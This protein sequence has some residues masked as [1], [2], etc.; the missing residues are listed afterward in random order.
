MRQTRSVN[1]APARLP[2]VRCRRHEESDVK[3]KFDTG[4]T[5]GMHGCGEAT[6]RISLVF[7][8]AQHEPVG[9]AKYLPFPVNGKTAASIKPHIVGFIGF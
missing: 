9:Y 2:I 8:V 4:Y 1:V 5:T 6:R 3:P 7:W